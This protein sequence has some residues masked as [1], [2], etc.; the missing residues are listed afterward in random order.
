MCFAVDTANYIS[1]RLLKDGK[2]R[3]GFI[4]IAGQNI[5]FHQRLVRF[6]DLKT[7]GGVLV[8]SIEP[9]SPAQFA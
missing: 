3:R 7:N 4:G 2:I 1:G 9:D 6:H 8:V 5:K